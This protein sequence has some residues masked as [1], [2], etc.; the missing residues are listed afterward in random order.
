MKAPT[1]ATPS[2]LHAELVE[3]AGVDEPLGAGRRDLDEL[4][5]GEEAAG[6]G[7]PDAGHAVHG[8]RAD[9]SSI[10]MRR[11]RRCRR[12]RSRRRPHRRRLPPRH[13]E[14]GRRGDRDERREHA[15]Q[16]LADVGLPVHPPGDG[17]GGEP[18]RSRCEVRGQRDVGEEADVAARDH[19]ERRARVEADPAEPEHERA[20]HR[21]RDVVAR[22]RMGAAV[23][24]EAPDAGP[25][26]ERTGETGERALEVHDGRAGEVLHAACANSQPR[27]SRSSARDEYVIVK[28]R[29]TGGRPRAWRARP[30]SPR[31]S[32]RR[33]RRTHLEEVAGG[34]G[35]SQERERRLPTEGS[36]CP[37]GG[38][39][40]RAE[41]PL[42]CRRRRCRSRPARTRARTREA[43]RVL[44]RDVRW[45]SFWR[46]R[47]ASSRAKPACMN[48]TR[49]AATTTQTV[50]VAIV[51]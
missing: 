25:E 44:A 30:S 28:L 6:E 31:R 51:S 49:V 38:S 3:R 41:T 34:D 5:C 24:A 45:R 21:E 36:S 35:S 27:D 50:L 42:P 14:A 20:E 1:A 40:L 7:A 46:V 23:V 12:R 29:R 8:D 2:S 37:T 10:P 15:V 39:P 13:D 22:G 9:G 33:R 32:R 11:R 17:A 48:S 47:P 16:D 26:D 4:G 19:A 43:E 18:A